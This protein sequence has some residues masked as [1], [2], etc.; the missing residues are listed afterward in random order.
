MVTSTTWSSWNNLSLSSAQS[1]LNTIGA[2]AADNL[3]SVV[4]GLRLQDAAGIIPP[5]LK[6]LKTPVDDF[7]VWE[8]EE[9]IDDEGVE[10]D[11][12]YPKSKGYQVPYSDT[13]HDI[14]SRHHR[15]PQEHNTKLR[16]Q[17]EAGP[18]FQQEEQEYDSLGV[19]IAWQRDVKQKDS[20]KR[21]QK[22]L[23]EWQQKEEKGAERKQLNINADAGLPSANIPRKNGKTNQ[24]KQTSRCA[25]TEVHQEEEGSSSV[26]GMQ[27]DA[28]V[29]ISL[30]SSNQVT[31]QRSSTKRRAGRSVYI[32]P[33]PLHMLILVSKV[34]YFMDYARN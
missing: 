15:S 22:L 20:K 6:G 33:Q 26:A 28:H 34:A 17:E 19:S 18:R 4:A 21:K 32:A 11:M 5:A 7:D 2:V 27:R 10:I 14:Y 9:D 1:R 23:A 25:H 30:P 13:K 8:P 29:T 16:T 31:V 24:Q 12:E 3:A